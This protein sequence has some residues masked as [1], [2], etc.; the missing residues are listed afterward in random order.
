MFPGT[1][2]D[3]ERLFQW[4]RTK[5][6]R[7]IK[8]NP[9]KK[10]WNKQFWQD[11]GENTSKY[12]QEISMVC[13]TASDDIYEWFLRNQKFLTEENEKITGEKLVQHIDDDEEDDTGS[14]FEY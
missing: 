6:Q 10:A 13:E 1:L 3:G 9:P 4:L 7:G 5:V 12:H 11:E 8:K 14:E 2:E